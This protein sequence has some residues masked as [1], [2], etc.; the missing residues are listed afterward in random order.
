MHF[1][2]HKK[3]IEHF[4]ATPFANAAP[5]G[6]EKH[7]DPA[8]SE[9]KPEASEGSSI[10]AAKDRNSGTYPQQAG[11]K[12]GGSSREAAEK[13]DAKTVDDIAYNCLVEHGPMGPDELASKLRWN[14]LN[15]RPALSRLKAQGRVEKLAA[16]TAQSTLNNS[17]HLYRALRME[18][19]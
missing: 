3:F 7:D 18:A 17:A 9:V 11:F 10:S 1:R 14:V 19:A 8:S 16:G 2:A 15:A 4:R 12:T 6:M 5:D 13:I